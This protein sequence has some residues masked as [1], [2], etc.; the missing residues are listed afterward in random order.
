[1]TVQEKIKAQMS[2]ASKARTPESRSKGGELAWKTRLKNLRA[3]QR[4]WQ[5]VEREIARIK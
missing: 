3:A 1:M 4:D 2:K 5:K